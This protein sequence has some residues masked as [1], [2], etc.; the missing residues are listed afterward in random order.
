[1]ISYD[2][3]FMIMFPSDSASGPDFDTPFRFQLNTISNRIKGMRYPRPLSPGKDDEPRLAVKDSKGRCRSEASTA[4]RVESGFP[5]SGNA[6]NTSED[7]DQSLVEPRVWA[8]LMA[9]QSLVTSHELGTPLLRGV[10]SIDGVLGATSDSS[11]EDRKTGQSSQER[12]TEERETLEVDSTGTLTER[13]R[14]T[15]ATTTSRAEGMT[16]EAG[17][18]RPSSH[19][20]HSGEG[21]GGGAPKTRTRARR[22]EPSEGDRGEVPESRTCPASPSLAS[23]SSASRST[24]SP[25]PSSRESGSSSS[26][27]S[28]TSGGTDSTRTRPSSSVGDES[29]EVFLSG[30]NSEGGRTKC[31]SFFREKRDGPSVAGESNERSKAFPSHREAFRRNERS[32]EDEGPPA[33]SLPRGRPGRTKNRRDD[34]GSAQVSEAL[35]EREEA[36]V[37]AADL[38]AGSQEAWRLA[39]VTATARKHLDAEEAA[40]FR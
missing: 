34:R 23:R 17:E 31:S 11:N 2:I 38:E 3:I 39:S 16:V 13:G 25:S 18:A 35:C 9:L 12:E 26:S 15:A 5:R 1:M 19:D 22:G 6:P 33:T 40:L 29:P 27:N 10:V 24:V 28:S 7:Q 20:E 14:P 4:A 21:R 32:K 37:R 8:G 30:R 36:H